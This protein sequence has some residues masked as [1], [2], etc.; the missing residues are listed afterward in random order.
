MFGLRGKINKAMDLY[1]SGEYEKSLKL[2]Q[3]I[4]KNDSSYVSLWITAG[5]VFYVSKKYEAAIRYYREALKRAPDNFSAWINWAN[6]CIELKKYQEAIQCAAQG[7]KINP[8]SKLPYTIMGN[9]YNE[10]EKYPESITCLKEALKRDKNDPWLHNYLSQSYQKN[11]NYIDSLSSAWKAI[12]LGED[13]DNSHQINISYLFYEI[14]MEKGLDS[15]LEC[16][17]LWVKKYGTNP[18]VKYTAN[19]L[20]RNAQI[21]RADIS[22][23]RNIFDIFANKAIRYEET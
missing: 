5:N 23:V 3:D 8:D 21:K 4:L 6:S 7:I 13:G 14:A 20:M 18:I 15:I 22:Y 17:E 16:V 12:E 10:L 19:A 9:A 2:C 1:E 11:G